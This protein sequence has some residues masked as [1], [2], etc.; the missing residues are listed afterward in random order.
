MVVALS[1]QWPRANPTAEE[2]LPRRGTAKPEPAPPRVDKSQSRFGLQLPQRA[3]IVS[4][5]A[6]LCCCLTAEGLRGQSEAS[7]LS[8]TC[9]GYFFL[10]GDDLTAGME[11]RSG[12][13][14]GTR[15]AFQHWLRRLLIPSQTAC[16]ALISLGWGEVHRDLRAVTAAGWISLRIGLG[17]QTK[18]DRAGACARTGWIRQ[19]NDPRFRA[20]WKER[21]LQ[22]RRLFTLHQHVATYES[23][24][25]QL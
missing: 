2:K 13:G 1:C 4:P 15:D 11:P 20:G 14:D 10:D 22:F 8:Q 9:S 5:S 16:H 3:A 23:A 6:A 12:P 17:Y 7:D 24:F 19:C 18:T 21:R 25:A